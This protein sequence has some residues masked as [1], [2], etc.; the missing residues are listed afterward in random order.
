MV[1]V[2]GII[3]ILFIVLCIFLYISIYFSIM[4]YDKQ[5]PLA[6][7]IFYLVKPKEFLSKIHNSEV[8]KKIEKKLKIFYYLFFLIILSDICFVII[9]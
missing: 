8:R 7:L 3:E 5:F 1:I 9:R 2:F 4:H 6:L